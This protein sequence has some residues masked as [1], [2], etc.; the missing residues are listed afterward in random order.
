MSLTT[1]GGGGGG[2]AGNTNG[3]PGGAN[4]AGAFGLRSGTSTFVT[5]ANDPGGG[6]ALDAGVVIGTEVVFGL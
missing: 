4:S 2:G 3:K 1:F 5:A 6:G